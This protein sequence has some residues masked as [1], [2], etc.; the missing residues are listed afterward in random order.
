MREDYGKA[1][2]LGGLR[3]VAFVNWNRLLV[4]RD[5]IL[6]PVLHPNPMDN[7]WGGKNE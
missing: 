1:D 4:E 5:R 2:T 7:V 6:V 3:P